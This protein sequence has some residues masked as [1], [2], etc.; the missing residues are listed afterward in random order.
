MDDDYLIADV[1]LRSPESSSIS[2]PF[3]PNA[4]DTGPD[5]LSRL[6]SAL[7]ITPPGDLNSYAMQ[8]PKPKT[9]DPAESQHLSSTQYKNLA[10]GNNTCQRLVLCDRQMVSLAALQSASTSPF[11]EICLFSPFEPSHLSLQHAQKL[12]HLTEMT[13]GQHR[14]LELEERLSKLQGLLPE[15]HP[16]IFAIF[17]GLRDANVSLGMYKLAEH[18][19]QRA[20]SIR[21]KTE[22][23]HSPQNLLNR[24]KLAQVLAAQGRPKEAKEVYDQVYP[25]IRRNDSFIPLLTAESLAAES[26]K[27]Q[28]RIVRG[29]G[30]YENLVS[31]C[32]QLTQ[33]RLGTLGPYAGESLSAML[34]LAE[35]LII[36][37]I[38]DEG[39]RILCLLFQLQT[40]CKQFSYLRQCIGMRKL[41]LVLRRRKDYEESV[42]VARRSVELA[43]EFLGSEQNTTLY[44]MKELGLC[45]CAAGFFSESE[46]VCREVV[47]KRAAILG[48]EDL[49]T[50]DAMEALGSVLMESSHYEE[51][52]I[53]CEKAF[54]GLYKISGWN[55][56]RAVNCY[57]SLWKCYEAQGRYID[58]IALYEEV[59]HGSQTLK[60]TT[61]NRGYYYSFVCRLAECYLYEGRYP[62]ARCVCMNALQEIGDVKFPQGQ[63]WKRWISAVLAEGYEHEGQY[64]GAAS[65]YE[66]NIAKLHGTEQWTH[67]RCMHYSRRL[68]VCYEK[69]ERYSDA[70]ALYERS[71]E[72]IR[73]L[74]GPDNPAIAEIQGWIDF[75]SNQT[76]DTERELDVGEDSS[77]RNGEDD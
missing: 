17:E 8:F 29:L 58:G 66:Q 20:I 71:M 30:S 19:C 40:Q 26:L 35:S 73:D 33:L 43:E 60:D 70:L 57:E 13:I 65:L 48:E 18:W 53:W 6:F 23:I 69:L 56:C 38:Y 12:H 9:P 10:N 47:A 2:W 36:E 5:F 68:G 67:E 27:T 50:I 24:L 51:A 42:T 31:Y 28:I 1:F 41:A 44:N 72:E 34:L 16:A 25:G 45:L 77:P 55:Y 61:R 64:G 62:Q 52:T 22:E 21:Q 14:V 46:A 49:Y 32:S 76:S 54:R 39:M 75:I 4:V 7:S 59:V 37:S 63:D 11:K 74:N 15:T 3:S